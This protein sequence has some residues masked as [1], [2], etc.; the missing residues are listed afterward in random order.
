MY[1]FSPSSLHF[2]QCG[3]KSLGSQI[4]LG[5]KSWLCQLCK[6]QQNN[7]TF[8]NLRF[9]ICKM[10]ACINIYPI[11]LNNQQVLAAFTNM[12]PLLSF[13]LRLL[14]TITIIVKSIYQLRFFGDK[15]YKLSCLTLAKWKRNL[16]L[17]YRIGPR[18]QNKLNQGQKQQEARPHEQTGSQFFRLQP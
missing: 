14:L 18:I 16:V 8:L 6:L 15:Q 9:F 2:S 3:A 10:E 4:I 11:R 17:V 13:L 5:F 12:T 1:A 7:I